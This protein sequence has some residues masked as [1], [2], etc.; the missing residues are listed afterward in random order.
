MKH[1]LTARRYYAHLNCVGS[2]IH[3]FRLFENNLEN[4]R[5][6]RTRVHLRIRLAFIHNAVPQHHSRID[7]DQRGESVAVHS[8]TVTSDY[9]V[10]A[11]F[12]QINRTRRY[13]IVLR[14]RVVAVRILRILGIFAHD[15][16]WWQ[17]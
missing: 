1:I 17:V 10:R 8:H 13:L 15:L 14:A 6:E 7:V 16:R 12:A 11:Q 9:H 4:L 3:T 5:R 2:L